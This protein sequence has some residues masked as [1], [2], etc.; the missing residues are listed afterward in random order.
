MRRPRLIQRRD[1]CRKTIAFCRKLP[2]SNSVSGTLLDPAAVRL[3]IQIPREPVAQDRGSQ[4]RCEALLGSRRTS[5]TIPRFN[6]AIVIFVSPFTHV[7][8]NDT[9]LHPVVPPQ[10]SHFKHVPLRTM[11]KLPHS[12]Q[13]SPT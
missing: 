3:K 8:C 11:V 13:A 5:V 6:S 1:A 10:V 12:G 4:C 2:Q 9:Q 7:I